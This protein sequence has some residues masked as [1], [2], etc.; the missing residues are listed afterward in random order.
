MQKKTPVLVL[1][2]TAVLLALLIALQ[3]LTKPAGQI[4]TGSC[5]NCV[6]AVAA[7]LVGWPGGLCVAAASPFAAFLLG[8]G[9]AFFPLT[10]IIAAGNA[11]YVALLAWLGRAWQPVWKPA[12][13]VAVA[14]AAK[15]ATL[16]LAVV[17]GV[18]RFADLKPMQVET[19]SAMFSLPQLVTA[20]IGGAVAMIIVPVV[21]KALGGGR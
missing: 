17:Q 3:T 13:A 4:V 8:I 21:R 11:V 15:A 20:L 2:Q 16:W 10:P 7:W 12:L 14:S 5:V 1:T 9:P 19:F 18:C 6:L